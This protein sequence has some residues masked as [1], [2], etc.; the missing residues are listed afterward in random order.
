MSAPKK[1]LLYA[2]I[3]VLS[4][5]TVATAFKIA[6]QSLSPAGL[7]LVSYTAAAVILGIA[8]CVQGKFREIRNIGRREWGFIISLTVINLAMYFCQ[9]NAYRLLPAHIAQPIVYTWPVIYTLIQAAVLRLRPKAYQLVCLVISL[10]GVAV[11]SSSGGESH[12]VPMVGIALAMCT[13]L[14]LAVYW[15]VSVKIKT[16]TMTVLFI[17]FGLAALVMNVA[18]LSGGMYADLSLRGIPAAVY[19]GVFEMAVPFLFW[20][21]ALK[22]SQGSTAVSQLSFAIPLLSLLIISLVLHEPVTIT[23]CTGILLIMAGIFLSKYIEKRQGRIA[24]KAGI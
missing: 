20:I 10:A 18:A 8:V 17:S 5:S 23:T 12:A 2:S 1:A 16:N 3:A 22:M 11:I 7:L 9:F 13:A 4:W 21:P 19:A 14:L 24:V 6:L 15:M